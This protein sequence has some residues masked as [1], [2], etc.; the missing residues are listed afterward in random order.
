MNIQKSP[1]LI[2]PKHITS[3]LGGNIILGCYP[4]YS[5]L[6]ERFKDDIKVSKTRKNWQDIDTQRNF[7]EKL[8]N[9][10]NL[11]IPEELDKLSFVD[12]VSDGGRQL[13]RKYSSLFEMYKTLYPEYT[14]NIIDFSKTPRNTWDNIDN[15][16]EFF[17]NLM[18]KLDLQSPLE[19]SQINTTTVRSLGGRTILEKYSSYYELLRTLY[20]D[21]NWSSVHQRAPRNHWTDFE[22][23]KIFVEK[24][25]EKYNIQNKQDWY[26]LSYAQITETGGDRLLR[27][28]G[29][30]GEIL[31][32]VYPE[33]KW[34]MKKFRKKDKRS[35][36]WWLFQQISSLYPNEEVIE[37]YNHE[38]MTRESGQIVQFDIFIPSLNIAFE[39]QG[40]HHYK[41]TAVFGPIELYKTRDIEKKELCEKYNIKLII[42]PYWWDNTLESLKRDYIQDLIKE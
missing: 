21:E 16:K 4:K 38:E 12:I 9:K 18:K 23:I 30:F 39:Y 42:I 17:T 22:N 2:R 20:P 29:S 32:L 28:Y 31:K 14:W 10:K 11:K 6:V 35:A 33:E 34:N 24:L 41:D 36:Q 26:R 3:Y 1:Y 27:L 15:Q 40:I 13:L 5:E 25:K 8:A 19:L 37:E 7:I